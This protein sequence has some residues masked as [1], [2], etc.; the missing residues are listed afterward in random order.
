ML[1]LLVKLV[2]W[3]EVGARF[4]GIGVAA[5]AENREG[6]TVEAVYS[7]CLLAIMGCGRQRNCKIMRQIII[8]NNG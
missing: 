8:L 4:G 1:L 6:V 7:S 3:C 5:W 2:W